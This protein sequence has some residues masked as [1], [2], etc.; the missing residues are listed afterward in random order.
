M[1]ITLTFLGTGTSSGVPMIGCNCS[2]CLSVND[3]DK[4]LRTSALIEISGENFA[5]D[6]GPDFR[7]QMLNNDVRELH[8][9]VF[10]HEHKDHI[11][12]LDDIRAYNYFMNQP[13]QLYA[14]TQVQEALKREFHYIFSNPD[15]PGVPKIGLNT[16]TNAEFTP[17]GSSFG[18]TPIQVYHADLPVFGYRIGNLAYI[19]DANFIPDSELDKLTSLD[20]LVINALRHEQH[21]SHFT[22]NEAL[23]LIEKLQPKQAYLTHISHQ[24]GLH[25]T[26]QA[27]LPK[28][29]FI[30]YDGLKVVSS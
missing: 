6:A 18:W 21:Y 2:V 17:I 25:E 29:V 1:S 20:V 15:Y 30:A 27:S 23:E 11:A 4:R 14:T 26:V 19:T 5:I 12:G 24:L 10:T 8:G 7:A 9:I 16:I 28:N 22:L 3:K 13:M